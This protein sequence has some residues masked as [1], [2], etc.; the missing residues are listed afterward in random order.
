M[1]ICDSNSYAH[2]LINIYFLNIPVSG[3]VPNK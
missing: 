2:D 3:E 1:E